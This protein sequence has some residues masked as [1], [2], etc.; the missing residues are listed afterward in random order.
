MKVKRRTSIYKVGIIDYLK[1]NFY[2]FILFF[3]KKQTPIKNIIKIF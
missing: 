1:I 3:K 2:L